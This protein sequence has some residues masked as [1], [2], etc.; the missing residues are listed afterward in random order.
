MVFKNSK[1]IVYNPA[2]AN[3]AP[4]KFMAVS[5]HHDDIE[6]MAADGIGKGYDNPEAS[7]YAVVTTDGGGSA[8]SGPYADY[9]DEQM[10]AVRIKEQQQAAEI[11]RYHRLVLLNYTSA[12]VK[13]K[14]DTDIT[15]DYVQILKEVRPEIVY[16]H[17]ICDKHPTHVG[18]VLK[19]I[20]ACRRLPAELRPAKLYGCEVWRDL[21]W[22]DDGD[23]VLFDLSGQVELT[24]K[25]LTVF[26]SQVAGGKRYDLATAGRRRANATYAQSHAVDT[27]TAMGYAMDLT[28]LIKDPNADIAE[29]AAAHIDKF[30]A[31]VMKNLK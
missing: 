21:D 30:K 19:M 20:E 17:N 13:N 25:L 31:D 27:V 16:T 18:V 6:I 24:D 3:P 4:P 7:F 12:D 15:D 11:G 1:A 9:T 28:P 10:K 8:R 23:K 22:L 14:A 2:C 5:A 26:D 29:F